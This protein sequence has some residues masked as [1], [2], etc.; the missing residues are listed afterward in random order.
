M[1]GHATRSAVAVLAAVAAGCTGGSGGGGGAGGAAATGT[2]LERFP[3]GGALETYIEDVAIAEMKANVSGWAYRYPTILDASG[4][5]FM[6]APGMAAPSGGRTGGGGSAAFSTTNVQVPGVDEPDFVKNDGGHF[7]DLVADSLVIVDAVPAD[8]MQ[9]AGKAA[10]EGTPL[11]LLLH[12]DTAVVFSIA[13]A[14]AGMERPAPGGV[15]YPI[16]ATPDVAMIA[17]CLPGGGCGGYVTPVVKLTVFDVSQRSAPA[18]RRE[19]YIEGSYVAARLAGGKLHLVT[20]ARP[21][22]PELEYWTNASVPPTQA[23]ID[24]LIAENERRIRAAT[25][26]D[27]TPRVLDRAAGATGA[28]PRLALAADRCFKPAIVDGRTI[29]AVSTFD[30]DAGGA[31]ACAGIVAEAGEV[32]ASASSL[33]VAS[34]AWDYWWSFGVGSEPTDETR[35]HAF[36]IGGPTGPE[37][38]GSGRVPGRVLDQFAMDEHAGYLR[39]ATTTEASF[40]SGAP[41]RNHLFVLDAKSLETVGSIRD[42]APDERIFSTRFLGEKGYIVTFE[43]IDPLFALD[44]ADPRRPRV[45]G[46]L[47]VE[48]VS[49]YLHPVGADHLLAIGNAI[50]NNRVVGLDLSVFDVSDL[51]SPVLAHR[52]T[53]AGAYSQAQHEHK[54]FGY[55]EATRTLAVPLSDWQSSPPFAGVE[56]YDVSLASGFTLRGKIDHTDLATRLGWSY[57]PEVVR[58]AVIGGVLYSISN[59]GIKANDI[60]DPATEHGG[61]VVQ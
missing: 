35:V 15:P 6:P 41:R 50:Q 44:L 36:A 48:G 53:L 24:A 19:V 18:A 45:M 55:Y 54:A 4:P 47:K 23:D 60:L 29:L 28:T 51:A 20:S 32:Y 37:Y 5:T 56:V 25:L 34:Y 52:R 1:R 40:Q 2:R 58:T 10:I 21:P 57:A 26:E 30:L 9:V 33:Y 59:A 13:P 39:V 17:P 22:G 42:L 61:V 7:Y 8:R 31:P 11:S 14:P 43:Q 12:G 27:W 16:Y 38:V 3:S 49:T 46:E